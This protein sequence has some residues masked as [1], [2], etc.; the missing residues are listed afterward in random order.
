MPTTV[1]DPETSDAAVHRATGKTWAGWRSALDKSGCREAA[2]RDIVAAALEIVPELSPWWSQTVAVGY[3]RMVGLRD[4]NQ[5]ADGYAVSVSRVIDA[6]ITDAF[7]AF[8]DGRS[9]KRWLPEPITIRKATPDR[10]L[11]ITWEADGGSLEVSLTS[12]GTSRCQVVVQ[13][14]RLADRDAVETMRAFWRER[15]DTLRD[16]LER[17]G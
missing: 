2:H 14:A 5:K 1:A 15:M 16:L 6:P 13:H 7:R 9:R 12:K 11:R 10:S 8:K 3:E 17:N 4:A